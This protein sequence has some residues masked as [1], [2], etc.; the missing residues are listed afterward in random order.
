M[1]TISF[2]FFLNKN[3]MIASKV[4]N[5]HVNSIPY[6]FVIDKITSSFLKLYIMS[7]SDVTPWRYPIEPRIEIFFSLT[8]ISRIENMFLIITKLRKYLLWLQYKDC[9]WSIQLVSHSNMILLSIATK[10][11]LFQL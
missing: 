7:L 3:R 9:G 5:I 8:Y 11:L 6:L 2:L 10:V 1:S 4:S